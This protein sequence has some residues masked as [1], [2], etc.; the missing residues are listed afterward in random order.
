M[1][2]ETQFE[3]EYSDTG[4]KRRQSILTHSYQVKDWEGSDVDAPEEYDYEHLVCYSFVESKEIFKDAEGVPILGV[5]LL[6]LVELS[7]NSKVVGGEK[8][9]IRTERYILGVDEVMVEIA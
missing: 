4:T 5:C 9:F 2:K 3:V 6:R 1:V 7:Q 8:I